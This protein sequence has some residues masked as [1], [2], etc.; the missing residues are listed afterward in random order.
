MYVKR[1]V[2]DHL[3]G[4]READLDLCPDGASYAGWAVITGDNGSGKSALLRAIA[5]AVLGP[6]Q[7]R[8]LL[9]DP[10]GWVN[11]EADRGSV[12]V[13][14]RPD[15]ELDKTSRGGAPYKG[16]FW[17]EIAIEREEDVWIVAPTDIH[18][19]KK[20]GAAN[21]PWPEST[22]GWFITGYGPFRRLYGAA[23][24]A[25]KVMYAH[26][27][28]SRFATLFLEG[29]TLGEGEDWLRELEF[30][31]LD[32]QFR[33]RADKA[34]QATALVNLLLL[35]EDDF[36]RHG[37]RIEDIDSS[38]I[39]LR[40]AAGRRM[41]LG[42][43]SEGYRA[44]LAMLLDIFRQM[45]AVY[46]PDIVVQQ[47][48][49]GHFVDRPGVVMIDEIDAHLH[50][51]WQRDIGF[52]LQSHFPRVQFIVTTHSPLVCGAANAGRIY[53]LPQ[54]GESPPFRLSTADYQRVLAGKPDEILLTPA[55][56]MRNVR[57]PRAVDARRRYALLMSKRLSVGQLNAEDEEALD[58]LSLFVPDRDTDETSHHES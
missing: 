38:A 53:H 30:A 24:D 3:K 45:V 29:A 49:H 35:I 32:F 33:N 17:A 58:Q 8:A 10:T 19:K 31:R 34:P 16:T 28:V 44:A 14:I 25:H 52:W 50:P 54:A 5:L 12:S 23:P 27:R 21:G 40:D 6:D 36:L 46:G 47:D 56:G 2:I 18:R 20:K 55:F 22:D 48:G 15:G 13:E 9:P 39:W 43:M 11:V 4:F 26:G 42:E 51:D 41:S 7:T 1:V 37:V 57:S